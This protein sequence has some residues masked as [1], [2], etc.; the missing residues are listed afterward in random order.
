MVVR[1]LKQI[2]KVKE[3]NSVPHELPENKKKSFWS[4]VFFYSTQQQQIISWLDCDVRQKV[5]FIWQPA[6]TSSVVGPRRSSKSLTKAKHAPKK[7]HGHHLVVCCWSDTLQLSESQQNHYI[8]E[9]RSANQWDALKTAMPAAGI[10]QQNGP[11]SSP[12]QCALHNQ[13]FKSWTN[14]AMKFC[15]ICHIHLTSYQT[16]TTSSSISTTFCRENTSI[17]S[18]KQKCFQRVPRIPKHKFLCYSNK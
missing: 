5:D 4:V 13:Y 7:G 10:G 6:M 14:W 16:T 15:L 17:T 9:V 2:G 18:R 1:H 3:F 8:W 11:S 12:Q